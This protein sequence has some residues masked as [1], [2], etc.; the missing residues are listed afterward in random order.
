MSKA[1]ADLERRVCRALGAERRGTYSPEGRYASGSDDD[2]SGPFSIET[3]RVRRYGLRWT[4]LEQARKNGRAQRKPWVLVLAE[5]R[6]H[7]PIAIC[8]FGTF[9]ELAYLA[10]LISERRWRMTRA[11]GEQ[12]HAEAQ[13]DGA[14]RMLE[15]Q[16]L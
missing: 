16:G 15:D 2:G 1:W 12:E 11:L 8:D 10:G 13:V 6:T 3:K 4:W 5:H 9:V 7:E 14:L